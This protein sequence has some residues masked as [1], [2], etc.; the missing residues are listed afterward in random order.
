VALSGWTIKEDS[1]AVV[2]VDSWA[3]TKGGRGLVIARQE[4]A[5]V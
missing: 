4:R 3:D 1:L 5:K 2:V